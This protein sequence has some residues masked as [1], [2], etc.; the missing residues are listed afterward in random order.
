MKAFDVSAK[1]LRKEIENNYQSNSQ[2]LALMQ[3]YSPLCDDKRFFFI[4]VNDLV[5]YFDEIIFSTQKEKTIF[6]TI[7]LKPP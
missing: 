6:N 3:K 1:L 5:E 2:M 7:T 4:T